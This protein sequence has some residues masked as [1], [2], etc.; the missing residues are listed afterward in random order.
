MKPLRLIAAVAL[1]NVL[2]LLPWWILA[3]GIE[4]PLF[5]WEAGIVVGAFALL[6]RT[7]TTRI[8]A[9][10]VGLALAA[11]LVVGLG[12]SAMWLALG[13]PLNLIVDFWLLRSVGHLLTGALGSGVLVG[14]LALGL[15]LVLFVLV[16]ALGW[17]LAPGRPTTSAAGLF[18]P[19]SWW[20]RRRVQ[21]GA[22]LLIGWPAAGY[23]M[24]MSPTSRDLV[25]APAIR[26][27]KEQQRRIASARI[28]RE[29]FVAD[30]ARAPSTYA[31]LPGLLTKLEGADVVLGFVESYG[32]AALHDDRYASVL[33]PRLD[34]LQERMAGAGLHLASGRPRRAEPRRAIVVWARHVAQRPL[35]GQ[36]GAL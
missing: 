17:L 33:G 19:V 36:P 5:A 23:A 6:P 34:D 31:E 4:P 16:A 10:V 32:M 22:A 29:A 8:A 20:K 7:R 9:L 1:V 12:N 13:R 24:T 2:L 18:G 25:Q 11:F 3:G 28:E 21:V 35:A 27:A 15:V 14:V 30:L 26:L